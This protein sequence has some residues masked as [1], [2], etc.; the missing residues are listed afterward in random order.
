[1]EVALQRSISG[2]PA[3][4]STRELHRAGRAGWK[5]YFS[6]SVGFGQFIFRAGRV[7]AKIS[8]KILLFFLYNYYLLLFMQCFLLF[9][10]FFKKKHNFFILKNICCVLFYFIK[11]VT[12]IKNCVGFMRVHRILKIW[13]L[14]SS[15][16]I[17]SSKYVV[18]KRSLAQI[19]PAPSVNHN[20]PL[21]FFFQTKIH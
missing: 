2:G 20:P 10:F 8:I 7:R 12:K 14:M 15:K 6:G 9:F 5:F 18:L 1:M 17:F 16:I 21:N 4:L 11:C 3:G 13:S 19:P